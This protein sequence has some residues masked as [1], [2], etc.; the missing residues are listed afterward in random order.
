VL[1]VGLDPG[2]LGGCVVTLDGA[3]VAAAHWRSYTRKGARLYRVAWA[4][5][6]GD[7]DDRQGL[8][9]PWEVGM[10]L[11]R[12]VSPLA[13]ARSMGRARVAAEAAHVGRNART[14]LALSRFGGALVGPLESLDPD[15]AA[16]WLE[17]DEWRRLV[18]RPR[19][20]SQ[21]AAEAGKAASKATARRMALAEPHVATGDR[22][23]Y[24]RHLKA[25]E[26]QLFLAKR[27]AAKMEAARV[28][29]DLVRG[30][31]D[32]AQRV[33][34]AEHVYDAAGVARARSLQEA[35]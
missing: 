29:P 35:P 5:A 21:C 8:H 12:W 18:F 4:T 15:R 13:M 22:A 23:A 9:T 27:D 6:Q 30:L 2:R 17:P 3:A 19:W 7:Q 20:W 34:G 11:R 24:D 28:L 14:G 25:R 33:G 26:N 10:A 16:T 1:V 31:A 32:L